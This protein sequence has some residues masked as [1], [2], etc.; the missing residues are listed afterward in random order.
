MSSPTVVEQ[1]KALSPGQ[2]FIGPMEMVTPGEGRI[3][4]TFINSVES[5]PRTE[6]KEPL[7]T[8]VKVVLHVRVNQGL[9]DKGEKSPFT[10]LGRE[11]E[12]VSYPVGVVTALRASAQLTYVGQ[13]VGPDADLPTAADYD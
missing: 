7:A 9:V 5:A 6:G 4:L 10:V 1:L 11:E 8:G 2:V 3:A 13:R 12:L